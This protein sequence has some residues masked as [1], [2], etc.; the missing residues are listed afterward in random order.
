M[1]DRCKKNIYIILEVLEIKEKFFELWVVR[2][3]DIGGELDNSR[4]EYECKE[5]YFE[6]S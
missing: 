1:V 4:G 5:S 6:R 2:F 3:L